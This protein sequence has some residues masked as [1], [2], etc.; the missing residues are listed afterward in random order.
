MET[1]SRKIAGWVLIMIMMVVAVACTPDS[2]AINDALDVLALAPH[3]WSCFRN[4]QTTLAAG[5]KY[6][7]FICNATSRDFSLATPFHNNIHRW[8]SQASSMNLTNLNIQ[9][10]VADVTANPQL[11]ISPVIA[12]TN[13]PPEASPYRQTLLGMA[14]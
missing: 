12:E 6:Y 2:Q 14:N 1:S 4:S 7:N 5:V 9:I 11:R 10:T 3:H 13:Y 8:V